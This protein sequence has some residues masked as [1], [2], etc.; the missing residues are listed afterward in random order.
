MTIS[1]QTP[2]ECS[3]F[4]SYYN[5]SGSEFI[6][7]QDEITYSNIQKMTKTT[8]TA[9]RN[10]QYVVS[11]NKISSYK[12]KH[13]SSWNKNDFLRWMLHEFADTSIAAEIDQEVFEE[14]SD[15][16]IFNLVISLDEN[17]FIQLEPN[18]GKRMCDELKELR[19]NFELTVQQTTLS[20]QLL[21]LF[22]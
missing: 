14:L 1:D 10:D 12:S 17:K 16:A 19:R 22:I 11:N 6:N 2:I 9:P 18:Y 21:L 15:E 5:Y 20:K 13:V 8:T 3:D 7:N 4:E